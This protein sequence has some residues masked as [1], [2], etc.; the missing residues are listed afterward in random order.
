MISTITN[1]TEYSNFLSFVELILKLDTLVLIL[2][3]FSIDV[4]LVREI[5]D[6][7][8]NLKYLIPHDVTSDTQTCSEDSKKEIFLLED[9]TC[10]RRW[11]III[12][13]LAKDLEQ[14]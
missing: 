5:R 3:D 1:I 2:S 6:Y 10:K 4:W 8:F 9:S 11:R 13:S 12:S 7:I 14:E